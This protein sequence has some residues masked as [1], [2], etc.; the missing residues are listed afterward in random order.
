MTE[1]QAKSKT[2]EALQKRLEAEL[3][4][5]DVEFQMHPGETSLR[6]LTLAKADLELFV[7]MVQPNPVNPEV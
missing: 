7:K 5:A 2:L 1:E 4:D 3:I 6:E